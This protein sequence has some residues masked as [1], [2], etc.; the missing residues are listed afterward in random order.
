[1]PY[2]LA[3]IMLF[4]LFTVGGARLAYALEPQEVLVVANKRMAGSVTLAKYYMK[5][6]NIPGQNLLSCSLTFED[7][8]S[9]EDY[10]RAVRK[11]VLDKINQIDREINRIAAIVL[12]YGMPLKV[13]PPVPD[14]DEAGHIDKLRKQLGELAGSEASTRKKI[15]NQIDALL[16]TKSR[17]S[18]DSE[19]ALVKAGDYE[20]EGWQ[21]NPYFIGFQNQKK[22]FS[23]EQVLLVS[24]LD[25]PD[26]DSVRR[27]I[28]DSLAV[29]KEGLAGKAYFDARYKESENKKTAGYGRYDHSIYRAARLTEKRMEVILDTE[30]SLFKEQSCPDAALYCGWYSLAKYVDSFTW[31]RGAIGYHIASL[32]CASLRNRQ[33]QLWCPS[34]IAKGVAATLG[35]VYEPYVQGFPLPELFF[36]ALTEGY[37]SLGEAYLVS[38]PYLSWQMVLIGDPLYQPFSPLP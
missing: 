23:K 21:V 31:V 34:M 27:I 33:Q 37:M 30:P 36:G 2:I 26:R 29:E 1:M 7:V 15:K 13:A 35:P 10:D 12:I 8:L 16:A 20:L 32:E 22:K 11:K 25:G 14:W 3:F 6:R 38:L 18:L 17:A 28:D 5:A 4:C 9:R 24:R 19:L